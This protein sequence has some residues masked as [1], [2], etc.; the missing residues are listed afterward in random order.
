[1]L[2]WGWLST[3]LLALGCGGENPTSETA[4]PTVNPS[5]ILPVTIA[6]SGVSPGTDAYRVVLDNLSTYY[7]SCERL[8]GPAGEAGRASGSADRAA[9][10]LPGET[11]RYAI[12]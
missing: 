1:M 9:S 5:T 8:S 4:P 12:H 11:D 10:S 7:R 6:T 2:R 3:G